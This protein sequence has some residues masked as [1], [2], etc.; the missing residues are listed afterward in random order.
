MSSKRKFE[1]ESEVDRVHKKPK[2]QK[3]FIIEKLESDNDALVE[4]L[5][6]SNDL[7]SIEDRVRLGLSYLKHSFPDQFKDDLPPIVHLHQIY[8]IL[9]SRTQVDRAIE[10][11]RDQ[12][13]LFLFKFDSA[14]AGSQGE[15]LI[16]FADSFK[17]VFRKNVDSLPAKSIL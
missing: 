3:E 6:L 11:L 17:L 13:R 1:H 9:P 5:T 10:S 2:T 12:H 16:C 7:E 14:L 15:T 4:A 8:A